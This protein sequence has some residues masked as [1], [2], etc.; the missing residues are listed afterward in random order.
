ML[1]QTS[2]MYNCPSFESFGKYR[3]LWF[4]LNMCN[5]DMPTNHGCIYSIDRKYSYAFSI[6]IIYF[7][8]KIV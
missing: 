1:F 3:T 7:E 2:I 6:W 8:V 4:G 5:H